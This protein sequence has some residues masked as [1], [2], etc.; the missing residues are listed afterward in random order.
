MKSDQWP[1]L[2]TNASP[3]AIPPTAAVE[4]LNL[5]A[6]VPGQV[7][8]RGG[9]RKVSVVG[10]SPDLLDCF[11]YEQD[12]KSTLIVM[13]PDGS[14]A[15]QLS[16]SYGWQSS[17]PFEPRLNSP[18]L[19]TTGYTYRYVEGGED[20]YVIPDAEYDPGTDDPGTDG[21]DATINGGVANPQNWEFTL[22]SQNCE[23]TTLDVSYD[24]GSSASVADCY[25]AV[26]MYLC[27]G[28]DGGEAGGG[29]PPV[30][31]ATV[32]SA[33]RSVSAAFGPSSATVMWD[34]PLSDGGA[35]IIDYDVDMSSDGGGS[36]SPLPGAIDPPVVAEWGAGS[37]RLLVWTRPTNP[38]ADWVFEVD[39]EKS[40]NN[41]TTWT[42]V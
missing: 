27:D 42:G 24:G 37:V 8:V 3:F 11:P 34:S 15:A 6:H 25:E 1:G 16:P 36:S 29:T 32:P 33:P 2:V 18:G 7:S 26:S 9:I 35:P 22:D 31:G 38:P 14:V 40:T 12:G 41:G 23:A 4:Q 13:R 28:E 30:P 39:A 20:T 19:V 5:A 21:C 10:G 17:T